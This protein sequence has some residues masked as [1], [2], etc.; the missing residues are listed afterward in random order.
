VYADLKWIAPKG[1]PFVAVDMVVS[2]DGRATLDGTVRGIGSESDRALMLALRAQADALLWG[3]GTLRAEPVGR[4]VP[5]AMEPARIRRGLAAQ[6][7][8]VVMSAS[9]DVPLGRGVFAEPERAIVFV[10]K[11]TP[12]DAVERLRQRAIVQTVGEEKP[13]PAAAL[14]WL[15][16]ERG[17]RH[18]VC[19]G[20]PTLNHAL[21]RAG[22]VDELFL[23]LAPKL[24]A[25][26]GLAIISGSL[27]NPPKSLELL[28]VYERRGELFLRY[29][30]A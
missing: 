9:G 4:G 25:G 16:Q 7:L 12:R 20:G 29:A 23:T 11:Q 6:P 14:N 2:A 28:S 21:F 10:A 3:A 26:D 19:E 30:I 22:L 15:A 13:D 24:I 5:E 1:R 18:V 8:T 17:V 27:L